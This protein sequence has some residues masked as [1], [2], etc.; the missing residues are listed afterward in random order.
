MNVLV[1]LDSGLCAPC[2]VTTTR[3]AKVG[4][5]VANPLPPDYIFF[6]INH[7]CCHV[8]VIS[9]EGGGGGL[10]QSLKLIQLYSICIFIYIEILKSGLFIV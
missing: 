3:G 9:R 6:V 5:E 2:N 7:M 1:D 10:A 4:G 8:Q